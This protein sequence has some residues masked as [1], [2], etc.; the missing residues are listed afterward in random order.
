MYAYRACTIITVPYMWKQ[1]IVEE[2]YIIVCMFY[3]LKKF[4]IVF[5]VIVTYSGINYNCID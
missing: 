3:K 4:L 1:K 2:I 5:N